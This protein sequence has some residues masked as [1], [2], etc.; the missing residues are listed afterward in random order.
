MSLAHLLNK[1]VHTGLGCGMCRWV[2]ERDPGLGWA[3]TLRKDGDFKIS[4]QGN[5]SLEKIPGVREEEQ[6]GQDY[7]QTNGLVR[8]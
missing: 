1:N 4:L 2:V 8:P 5:S 7:R 3:E 6:G